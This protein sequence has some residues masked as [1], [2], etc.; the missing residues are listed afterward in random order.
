[1][2]Y[3]YDVRRYPTEQHFWIHLGEEHRSD[4]VEENGRWTEI[5]DST[6]GG[7]AEP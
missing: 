6:Q 7:E 5:T 4:L 3:E 2:C 1:M